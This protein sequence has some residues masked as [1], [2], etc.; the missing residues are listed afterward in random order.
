MC[1]VGIICDL[2]T[3]FTKIQNNT[4]SVAKKLYFWLHIWEVVVFSATWCVGEIYL[5]LSDLQLY[6]IHILGTWRATAYRV[7]RYFGLPTG[8][9]TLARPANAGRF[10]SWSRGQARLHEA[11]GTGTVGSGA[12]RAQHA[13]KIAR[14]RERECTARQGEHNPKT[15]PFSKILQ[16]FRICRLLFQLTDFLFKPLHEM[17]FHRRQLI[18]Y[19][20][21]VFVVSRVR[22]SW[23]SLWQGIR[24]ASVWPRCALKWWT[25]C[26]GTVRPS[27]L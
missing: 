4:L 7:L 17:Y 2:P 9:R 26:A 14:G 6:V 16:N 5:Y 23:Q 1:A 24:A 21:A 12:N 8:S 3:C 10:R 18:L 20:T 15:L 11:A 19:T 27:G 25:C 13:R 22:R